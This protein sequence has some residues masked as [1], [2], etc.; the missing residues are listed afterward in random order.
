MLPQV[1]KC[2]VNLVVKQCIQILGELK[3]K[4]R[5]L[6]RITVEQLFIISIMH[7]SNLHFYLYQTSTKSKLYY[8]LFLFSFLNMLKFKQQTKQ[9]INKQRKKWDIEKKERKRTAEKLILIMGVLP[10]A[11]CWRGRSLRHLEEAKHILRSGV[12]L[13]YSLSDGG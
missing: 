6:K 7:S 13:V 1:L 11:G 2:R 9:Q 12:G 4:A 5:Y 8:T 3:F 10:Q